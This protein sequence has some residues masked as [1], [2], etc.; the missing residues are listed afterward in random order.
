MPFVLGVGNLLAIVPRFGDF[1]LPWLEP[2]SFQSREVGV[3]N[4]A[5]WS[6]RFRLRAGL[7][8]RVAAPYPEVPG[9]RGCRISPPAP[10][11]ELTLSQ[12]HTGSAMIPGSPNWTSPHGEWATFRGSGLLA[13]NLPRRRDLSLLESAASIQ[14]RFRTCGAP[15][16]SAPSTSHSASY[17]ISAR[18]PRTLA[19]PLPT[20]RGEFS[21]NAN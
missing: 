14:M 4:F 2:L 13:G 9:L 1:R 12:P 20:S 5:I 15:T 21:K 17:P 8:H 7:S 3:G 6:F 11:A 16:S 18:S 10:A 19:S